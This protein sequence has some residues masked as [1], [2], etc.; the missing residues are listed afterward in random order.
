MEVDFGPSHVVLDGNPA[1]LKR[2]TAPTFWPCLLWSNS[3]MDQDATWYKGG[4]G[5]GNIV[6]DAD[7]AQPPPRGNPPNFRPM[8]V[9]DKRLPIS[10]IAE[11]LYQLVSSHNVSHTIIQDYYCTTQC[12]K[13]YT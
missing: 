4:L 11:H 7:P 6:F 5:P 12:M 1:P 13:S 10:A 2:G 8:S 9:V 3:W